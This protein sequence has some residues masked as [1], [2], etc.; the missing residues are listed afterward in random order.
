MVVVYVCPSGK[1]CLERIAKLNKIP[2]A[3]LVPTLVLI[4]IPDDEDESDEPEQPQPT[5]EGVI[6]HSNLYGSRLLRYIVADLKQKGLANMVL[7]VILKRKR[8]EAASSSMMSTPTQSARNSRA[9]PYKSLP[10]EAALMQL[11]QDQESVVKY[12]NLGAVSAIENP[13][14]RDSLPSLT[15]QVYRV[16]KEF[17]QGGKNLSAETLKQQRSWPGVEKPL[18]FA[19]LRDVMVSDLAGQICGTIVDRP[20]DPVRIHLDDEQENVVQGAIADWG[21]SA[22]ALSDDE[23]LFAAVLMVEHALQM[24]GLEEF[25]LPRGMSNRKSQ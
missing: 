16:H 13:I 2:T 14:R 18:P 19:Y 5:E 21:F 25:H 17:V 9:N 24:P 6:D 4:E 1:S 11:P 10:A 23:L 22:H 7:P 3:G 20:L 15:I 12:I 8:T